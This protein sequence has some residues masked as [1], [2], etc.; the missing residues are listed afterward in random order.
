MTMHCFSM[1]VEGFHEGISE[2]F[3]GAAIERNAAEERAELTGNITETLAFLEKA[4]IHGTFFVLGRIARDL[5][6][7][8]RSIAEGGHEVASHS[9][10]H[11]RL[12]GMSRVEARN[13]IGDSKKALEDAIGMAVRGFRAPDFSIN[14][15]TL[16]LLDMVRDSGYEYDCSLCP[17]RRRRCCVLSAKPRW[18]HR[19]ENGLVEFP[20]SVVGIA[21]FR[22]PALG[23]GYFRLYPLSVTRKILRGIEKRG[24]SAM[25]YIHPYE[26]ASCCPSLPGMPF[27]GTFRHYVNRVKTKP[28]F[29]ELFAEFSFGRIDTVL[30]DRGF[31]S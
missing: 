29:E 4:Q 17:A 28:R 25:F 20:P 2:S 8:V 3:V 12:Y 14:D 23:G 22:V 1:D 30:R 7:V 27:S 5:P 15:R 18:I 13:A 19:L 9:F 21:G 24:Q 11:R 6:A 16:F 31:L 10:D 26:L